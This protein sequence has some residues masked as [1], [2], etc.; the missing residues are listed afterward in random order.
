MMSHYDY[1]GGFVNKYINKHH[2]IAALPDQ[3][4]SLLTHQSRKRIRCNPER[5]SLKFNLGRKRYRY[6]NIQ[7]L[8]D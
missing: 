1:A 3:V 2:V 8:I 5:L 6:H 7:D 4:F